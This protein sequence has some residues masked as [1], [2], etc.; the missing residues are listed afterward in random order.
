[1]I[2][3][4]SNGRSTLHVG[5]CLE[6]M[7]SMPDG[8][9]TAVVTDPPYGI[10]YNALAW[11]ADM[12]K[13]EVWREMLRVVRPG[14]LLFSFAA[15]RTLH[16]LLQ[17]TAESGWSY[18]DLLLWLYGSGF[19]KARRVGSRMT[20]PDAAARWSEH[21]TQLR[22]AWEPIVYA[23]KP[24]DGTYADNA[25]KYGVAGIHIDANRSL[26]GVA[27]QTSVLA[28]LAGA[29]WPANVVVDE[30]AAA[31]IDVETAVRAPKTTMRGRPGAA[32]FGTSGFGG[33][34]RVF[35]CAKPDA[36]ERSAGLDED[37]KNFH[38]TVKPVDLMRWLVRF[39]KMPDDAAVVL[40]PFCGSGTTGIA[41][42][43]EGMRFVGIDLS[44]RNVDMSARRIGS[45]LRERVR[46]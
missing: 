7:R 20:D 3:V 15:A 8:S 35:Y 45:A 14:G 16:T 28:G 11:D 21:S 17:R 25:L 34:S 22:S 31:Q 10:G 41:C 44:P 13:T 26:P 23:S 46:R 9:I 32:N 40:D 36:N 19:P 24:C 6:V 12:P 18:N 33:V 37:D 1:M 5:D 2:D 4:F 29:A 39:A 38:P 42:A 43:Q 30:A 27:S